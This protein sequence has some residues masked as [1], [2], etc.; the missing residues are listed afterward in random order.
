MF[1]GVWTEK[2]PILS[3]MPYPVS[4]FPLEKRQGKVVYITKLKC[5]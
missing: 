4:H 5:H 3:M 2:L 1:T